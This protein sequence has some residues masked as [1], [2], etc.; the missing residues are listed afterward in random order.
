MESGLNVFCPRLI[1]FHFAGTDDD[2]KPNRLRVWEGNGRLFAG[3][4]WWT[5]FY[6]GEQSFMEIP[7][8]SDG[9]DGDSALLNFRIGYL[10][11]EL[12]DRL[13]LSR[14]LVIDRPLTIWRCYIAQ[15]EGLRAVTP[16]GHPIFLTMKSAEFEEEQ[17][18]SPDGLDRRY[19]AGVVAR[20][21]DE[22]R[23]YA[24][25]DALTDVNQRMR[26]MA[27]AGVANDAYARFVPM[28]LNR[29]LVLD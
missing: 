14:D 4:E 20:S 1:D 7:E 24:P 11:K 25:G 15:G 3:G 28:Q 27:L 2:G 23:S 12:Y 9:R 10:P 8:I 18:L 21:A 17:F 22:G 5:G 16:L 26:A 13:R 6:V 19:V 29:R